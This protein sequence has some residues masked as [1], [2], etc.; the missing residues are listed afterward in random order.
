MGWALGFRGEEGGAQYRKLDS[1]KMAFFP[2]VETPG[3]GLSWGGGRPAF[4][5]F[6]HIPMADLDLKIPL[7]KEPLIL[8]LGPQYGTPQVRSGA[9]PHGS[10]MAMFLKHGGCGVSA[11]LTKGA[12]RFHFI[13]F[14]IYL[15]IA[16][17]GLH[18]RHKTV[19]RLGV[20]LELYLLVYT[21]AN[22]GSEPCLQ[23]T[24]QLTTRQDP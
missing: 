24:P 3:S 10:R 5:D 15:F 23:P 19:P 11:P 4:G 12:P 22:T 18:L 1:Q 6:S 7:F 8:N 9:L 2:S 21:M 16:S 20:E 17:L 13:S 14:Y